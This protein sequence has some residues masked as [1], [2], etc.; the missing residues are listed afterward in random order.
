MTIHS[1]RPAG[2]G[3]ETGP[4]GVTSLE[5]RYYTDAAIFAAE[6]ET[7]FF[8]SWLRVGHVTDLAQPGDYITATLFDQEVAVLRGRDGRLRAFHNV[9][10]HR[11]HR[12]LR[13][14]GN[15]KAVITCPY[16]A[17]S[18]DTAGALRNAPNSGNVPGFDASR[19]RLS[20]L[21]V[22]A[23]AGFVFVN[24]D[25]GAA[26]LSEQA[27]GLEQELY[28][29]APTA[30]RLVHAWRVAYPV[31]ANWKVCVE[32]WSECY[33]CDAVHPALMKEFIDQQSH[34]IVCHAI[35]Q[36]QY[37]NLHEKV[38]AALDVEA[39]ASM[40][41]EQASW[42]L[43]PHMGFQVVL[44][45]YLSAFTWLP[46]DAETTIFAEDW[47]FPSKELTEE[48]KA[49][50]QFRADHTQPEDDLVCEE[51]QRGLKSRGYRPGPLMTDRACGSMS[52]HSVQHLQQLARSALDGWTAG[53]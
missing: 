20:E 21:G 17:W 4:D 44:Q 30:D 24:F 9:C 19:I 36:R 11:G 7:I 10:R 38:T 41:R 42:T 51:V 52:E 46:V 53:R 43:W 23:M 47:F 2:S 40:R 48:Q 1:P 31:K 3:T 28:D 50:I 15:V 5:G 22:D 13:G 49:L 34:R 12:L 35:W 45:G 8:R 32:N 27:P 26:P 33:H 37:M 29:F 6:K 39:R 16:H 18:Y 25:R 14:S